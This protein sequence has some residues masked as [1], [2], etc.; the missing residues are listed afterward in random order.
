MEQRRWHRLGQTQHNRLNTGP[1]QKE[2]A[3]NTNGPA[4]VKL[5]MQWQAPSKPLAVDDS[6][7]GKTRAARQGK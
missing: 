1:L 4:R 6:S 3:F 7:R 2:T 5:W